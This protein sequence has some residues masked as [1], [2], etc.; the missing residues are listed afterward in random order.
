[1]NSYYSPANLERISDLM[2]RS[3]AA[4]EAYLQFERQVYEAPSLLSQKMKEL[5]ALTVAHVTGCPYCIDVHVKKFKAL[6]GTME[7]IMEALLVAASTRA[8]AILS[9]GLNALISHE[10]ANGKLPKDDSKVDRDPQCFC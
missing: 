3:P 7:E 1:M 2:K 6:D 5:I 8:G 10:E 4:A 9:H